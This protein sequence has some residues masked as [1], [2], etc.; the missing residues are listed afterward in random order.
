MTAKPVRS[1]FS[2]SIIYQPHGPRGSAMPNIWPNSQNTDAVDMKATAIALSQL[3]RSTVRSRM[4]M[5]MKL[6]TEKPRYGIPAAITIHIG[7]LE[8]SGAVRR[9][10]CKYL[11]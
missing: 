4:I 6:V 1:P 10:E 9:R 5:V 2:A 3:L 8:V 11:F 7:Q